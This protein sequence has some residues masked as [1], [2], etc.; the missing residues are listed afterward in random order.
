MAVLDYYVCVKFRV[1]A[2]L[3]LL[4]LRNDHCVRLGV[5]TATT[6]DRNHNAGQALGRF[7]RSYNTHNS[8]QIDG[9]MYCSRLGASDNTALFETGAPL[10]LT[11]IDGPSPITDHQW[12]LPDALRRYDLRI[13]R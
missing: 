6:R 1:N 9:I 4:D 11:V 12:P 7:V 2:E 8:G 5:S 10:P 3:T 13:R